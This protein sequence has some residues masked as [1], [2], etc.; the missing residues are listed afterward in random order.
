[1]ESRALLR[2]R[3]QK[4]DPLRGVF[5]VVAKDRV[6]RGQDRP[7]AVPENGIDA[8]IRKNLYD[9]VGSGHHFAS[10]RVLGGGE[11]QMRGGGGFAGGHCSFLRVWSFSRPV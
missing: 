5:L 8:F 1:H 7:A 9:R 3:D 11:F 10:Q 4:V 6:V 2:S